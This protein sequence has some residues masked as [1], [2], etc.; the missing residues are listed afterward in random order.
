MKFSEPPAEALS[1]AKAALRKRGI[2]RIA[3]LRSLKENPMKW[4]QV[5]GEG[6]EDPR[7]CTEDVIRDW[8]RK[9]GIEA[10]KLR[11]DPENPASRFNLWLRY[12][13]DNDPHAGQSETPADTRGLP[14]EQ[15][16]ESEPE[17]DEDEDPS[18][19]LTEGLAGPDEDEDDAA[20][21][22]ALKRMKART[23]A[24][25]VPP[26]P[27]ARVPAPPMTAFQ[28]AQQEGAIMSGE[29]AD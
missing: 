28:K 5:Y 26:P 1:Q 8:L 18:E 2:D 20:S 10:A 17:P 6:T 7:G 27:P 12:N 4:A 23:V 22:A 24:P 25:T 15:S 19:D 14:E 29:M 13:P 11:M 3:T 21:L 16:A 9:P